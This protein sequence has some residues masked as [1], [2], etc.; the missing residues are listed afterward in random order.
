MSHQAGATGVYQINAGSNSVPVLDQRTLK[1]SPGT[2]NLSANLPMPIDICG[3]TG[4]QEVIRVRSEEFI[5]PKY[6]KIWCKG[7]LCAGQARVGKKKW[8]SPIAT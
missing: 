3:G 7:G 5:R 2:P 1:M 8:P 6:V 4:S